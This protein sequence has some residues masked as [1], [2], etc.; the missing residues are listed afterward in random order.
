MIKMDVHSKY[1]IINYLSDLIYL[2]S[3]RSFR[4]ILKMLC[5]STY[6]SGKDTIPDLPLLSECTGQTSGC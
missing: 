3:F 6:I 4:G 5:G 1:H 2:L